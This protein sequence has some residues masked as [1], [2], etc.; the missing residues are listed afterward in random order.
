VYIRYPNDLPL[1]QQ[2]LASTFKG[3]NKPAAS[4]VITALPHPD[5]LVAM[6]AVAVPSLHMNDPNA[7][8]TNMPSGPPFDREIHPAAG[9]TG[10]PIVYVSGMADTNSLPEAT[11]VTLSKLMTAIGHLGL[12]KSDIV[13]LKAFFQPMSEAAV[14]RKEIVD[15]FQ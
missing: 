2:A 8:K 3:T 15:F 6:D 1:V 9:F 5:A 4:F 12:G 14:V 11:R 10:G 13:Q 7:W